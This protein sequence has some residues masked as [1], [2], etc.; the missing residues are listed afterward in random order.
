MDNLKVKKDK[1]YLDGTLGGAGHGREILRRGGRLV[2]VDRDGDAIKNAAGVLRE[3]DDRVKLIQANFADVGYIRDITETD[4]FDGILLDLGVSSHQLDT[5][6]RGFSYNNAAPLD[7]RMDTRQKFTAYHVVNNYA[8]ADLARVIAEYSEERWAVRIAQFIVN[9]RSAKPIETTHDLVSVIMK[10]IPKAARAEGPHPAKR[11]FQAIRIEVNDE[12]G[13]LENAVKELAGMLN[14]GGRMC[15]ITFHSLEDRIIKN[16]Y[17]E[18]ENPC[19]C[20]HD[21]P[22]CGCGR[23]PVVRVITRKPI[24]PSEAELETNHRARSAKLRVIEKL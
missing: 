23:K 9:A 6:G 21:L 24:L 18:M 10:A 5:T 11:T 13:I 22:I 15:V 19:V 16:T 14:G 2:G 7:M 17:R 1:L 20:P 12:L 3:Y 4:G 8:E